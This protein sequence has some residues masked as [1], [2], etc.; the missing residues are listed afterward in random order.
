MPEVWDRWHC[1]VPLLGSNVRK[2]RDCVDND[3]RPQRQ[4]TGSSKLPE[5][6]LCLPCDHFMAKEGVLQVTPAHL[7]GQYLGCEVCD[8]PANTTKA[9]CRSGAAYY[10]RRYG[11]DPNVYTVCMGCKNFE[12]FSSHKQSF[13]SLA[14]ARRYAA[15]RVN[16]QGSG[17]M[18]RRQRY[19]HP[20][21]ETTVLPRQYHCHD[22]SHVS[23]ALWFDR[24]S[25]GFDLHA[26]KLP[27]HVLQREYSTFS[28]TP[29]WKARH[30]STAVPARS[31]TKLDKIKYQI[32]ILLQRRVAGRAVWP[33]KKAHR[34]NKKGKSKEEVSD[35]IQD[36]DG[37]GELLEILDLE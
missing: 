2:V 36:R 10:M 37:A 18:A 3:L 6:S 25:F 33:K 35:E 15:G 11:N 17:T 5:K 26:D 16:V 22:S 29:Y 19:T 31:L 14:D 21:M 4:I 1:G 34:G 13:N 30:E 20:F 32:N 27:A 24:Q 8:Y 12:D 9:H 7:Y 23:L 28:A